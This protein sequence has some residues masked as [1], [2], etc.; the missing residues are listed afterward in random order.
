MSDGSAV[1]SP[2]YASIELTLTDEPPLVEEGNTAE[3]SEQESSY[4]AVHEK[5]ADR[6]SE[7]LLHPET[8][9][10]SL[11]KPLLFW[12]A[13]LI[14]I[15]QQGSISEEDI[16]AAPVEVGVKIN[17]DELEEAYNGVTCHDGYWFQTHSGPPAR[18]TSGCKPWLISNL[19]KSMPLFGW[20]I[21]FAFKRDILISGLYQAIFAILQLTL[22]FLIGELLEYISTGNGGLGYGFG[23]VIALGVVSCMSSYCIISTFYCMRRG[24]LKIKAS[25]MM[26]VYRQSLHL[27][28]ASRFVNDF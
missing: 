22:P 14:K 28:T 24:S 12:I 8:A 2:L 16:W 6:L 17:S 4:S 20:A 27:T 25:T 5:A 13:P 9:G 7:A 1:V 10:Y 11:F 3:G 15:A 26:N 23:I 18:I 19:V 21:W